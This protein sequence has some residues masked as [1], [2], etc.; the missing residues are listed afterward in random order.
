MLH[1]HRQVLAAVATGAAAMLAVL[2]GCGSS[3]KGVLP[4]AGPT[5][6]IGVLTDVTGPASSGNKTAPDGVKAGVVYAARQGYTIR[7]VVADTGTNPATA[8]TAAQK[9]VTQDHVLAVI[10]HSAITYGAATFLTQRKVPVIGVPED[11]SEWATS[12]NMFTATGPIDQNVVT[13]TVGLI[14][15]QLGVTTLGSIGYGV[16]PQ[17]AA[18]A[19]ASSLSAKDAGLKVGYLNAKLVFGTT[20]VGPEVL[21]MKNAGVDGFTASVDPNTSLAIIKGLKGQGV[22]IRAALLPAGYGGDLIS[23]GPGALQDAQGVYFALQYEPTEMNTA[24]TRQFVSDLNAAGVTGEATYAAYNG[25]SSVG[26]LVRALK[27]A[28]ANPTQASLTTA[29]AGIHDWDALGLDSGRTVDPNAKEP[30]GKLCLYVA[31]YKG[32]TFHLVDGM[33]PL[34]GDP[35]GEK[36]PG[37]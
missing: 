25:Y 2:T 8:L 1:R 15:K 32:T 23:S 19:T 4:A 14:F 9:L 3:P 24:A 5:I 36:V 13:A 7:Y 26:L 28:G 6:T 35:T 30:T 12:P 20:D 34:C 22:A 10:A 16:S 31:Q 37:A 11:G 17:S 27:A 21:A 18:S 29:L 33:E